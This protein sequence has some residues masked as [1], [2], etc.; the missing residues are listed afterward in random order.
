MFGAVIVGIFIDSIKLITGY[1]RPYFFNV[2]K[3][4]YT[5]CINY[6]GLPFEHPVLERNPRSVCSPQALEAE[7]RTAW[8]A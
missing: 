1:Q 4:N 5:A 2:C 7:L 3:P 6:P 8:W